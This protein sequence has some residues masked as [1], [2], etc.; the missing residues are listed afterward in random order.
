MN[1]VLNKDGQVCGFQMDGITKPQRRRKERALFRLLFDI[2]KEQKKFE[3]MQKAFPLD[4]GH[5]SMSAPYIDR[6]KREAYAIRCKLQIA[7]EEQLE[8]FI[9]RMRNEY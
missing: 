5:K 2:E 6:M 8:S 7:T 9:E 1:K 3:D 4:I